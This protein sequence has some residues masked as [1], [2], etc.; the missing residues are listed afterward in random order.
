MV[1]LQDDEK[2]KVI[3]IFDVKKAANLEE[4]S[5]F[6]C[7]K[8][9]TNQWEWAEQ[10]GFSIQQMYEKLGHRVFEPIS[11]DAVLAFLS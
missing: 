6:K 11:E 3:A 2:C 4:E 10:E 7:F 5:G 1:L 9:H 8:I